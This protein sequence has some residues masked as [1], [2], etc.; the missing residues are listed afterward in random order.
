MKHK[1]KWQEYAYH[2]QSISAKE[3][4]KVVFWDKKKFNLDSPDGFQKDKHAKNFPE[5]NYSTRFSGGGYLMV[6]WVD[7]QEN[8]TTVCQWLTKSSRL[9]EDA[10][11]FI[12]CTRRVL[13]TLRRMD[14]S[15][16]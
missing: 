2:Y 3:G 15:A 10:K 8:L 6:W 14:F 12:S 16:S 7:L 1:E 9:C 13:S 11:W 4:C 5:E